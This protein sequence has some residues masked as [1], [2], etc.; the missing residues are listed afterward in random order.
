MIGGADTDTANFY[1]PGLSITVAAGDYTL[2]TGTQVSQVASLELTVSGRAGTDI[3]VE[4]ERVRLGAC[5]DTLKLSGELS[6]LM[7]LPAVEIIDP[8]IGGSSKDTLDFT[9]VTGGQLFA[10]GRK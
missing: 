9:D 4:M 5:S 7:S 8:G 2:T 1:G 10:G 3:L 6:S